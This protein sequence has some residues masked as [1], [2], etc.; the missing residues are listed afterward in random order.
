MNKLTIG[1]LLIL[2]STA[3]AIPKA[4]A[5][6]QTEPNDTRI[7][8]YDNLTKPESPADASQSDMDSM[9]MK[10]G[11]MNQGQMN[12][13]EGMGMDKPQGAEP[14]TNRSEETLDDAQ[15]NDMQPGNMQP[16]NMKSGGNMQSGGMMMGSDVRRTE[17]FNLVSSAY[18]GDF[19]KQGIDGYQVLISDYETGKVTADDLIKAGIDS[20]DLSPKAAEDDSYVSAVDSQLMSLT[21]R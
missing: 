3:F 2:F 17:A 20:G 21:N 16:G 10:Q 13:D 1:S 19:E 9:E 6:T 8:K 11:Q 12:Q 7:E 15:S 18:R 4:I 14:P 5:Q